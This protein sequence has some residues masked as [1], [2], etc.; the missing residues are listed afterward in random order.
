[1][2]VLPSEPTLVSP[3]E[4]PVPFSTRSNESLHEPPLCSGGGRSAQECSATYQESTLSLPSVTPMASSSSLVTMA[5][6]PPWM[7]RGSR[8]TQLSVGPSTPHSWPTVEVS[9]SSVSGTIELPERLPVQR[10]AG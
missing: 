9:L 4:T 6:T 5:A 7:K 2:G 8:M 1:M 3:S 10:S